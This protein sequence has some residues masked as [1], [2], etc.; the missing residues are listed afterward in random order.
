MWSRQLDSFRSSP[1]LP[2]TV[3]GAAIEALEE[4]LHSNGNGTAAAAADGGGGGGKRGGLRKT[5]SL[6]AYMLRK[7]ETG[8]FEQE[9]GGARGS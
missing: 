2:Y 5:D 1:E 4:Q 7:A 3:S 8:V 9:M 6:Q